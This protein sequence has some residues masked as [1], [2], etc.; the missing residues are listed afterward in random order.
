LEHKNDRLSKTAKARE[1]M[2]LGL[3]ALSVAGF[4]TFAAAGVSPLPLDPAEGNTYD[5]YVGAQ[6]QYDDNLYRVSAGADTVATLVAPNASRGDRISTVSAGGDGQW[7]LGRQLVDVDLH[8]D[9]NRFADNTVLNNTSGLA[10]L[11]WDWQVG[12]YFSGTAGASYSHTLVSFGETLYLGRDFVNVGDYFGTAKYQL[13]PHWALYG[14]VNDSSVDH[15]AVQAEDQ[16]F[17]TQAGHAGVEYALDTANTL[18][19]EYRFDQGLFREGEVST[20]DGNTYDPNFHDSTLL[21]TATHSFSDKTQVVAD[22]GYLKRYYPNTTIGSFWGYIWRVTVNYQPTDKTNIAFAGW[23][24]LHAYL[25]AQSDYFISQGAS[26][27]P[28]WTPTDRITVKFLGSYEHQDY[29]PASVLQIGPINA[30]V[31]LETLSFNY[32][33]REHWLLSLGYSHSNRQS[34]DTLF[35]YSD[36]LASFSVLYTIH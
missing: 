24:E 30:N 8:V 12:P 36:N 35:R 3:L 6:E 28:T 27:T 1:G 22:A 18:S 20:L 7:L 17:R 19:F 34:D 32:Q 5:L 31:Q 11:L 25:V 10:K 15:T 16:S 14:G 2:A 9:E 4:P 29:I 26:I 21:F 23:H 33:P 13:G